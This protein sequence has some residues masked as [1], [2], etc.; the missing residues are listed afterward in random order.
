MM[1]SATDDRIN[2]LRLSYRRKRLN[3]PSHVTAL[4]IFATAALRSNLNLIRFEVIAF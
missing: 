4:L 3:F 2:F 1:M